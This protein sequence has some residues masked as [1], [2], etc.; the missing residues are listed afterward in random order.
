MKHMKKIALLAAAVLL[1]AV[2]M[3]GCTRL[4]EVKD[5]TPAGT[6]ADHAAAEPGEYGVYFKLTR[7]DVRSVYLH[8]GSFT[9]VC[10]N[11][12]GSL[13]KAGDWVFTGED[14]RELS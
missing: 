7:D 3:T 9:K 5:D 12:D 4:T 11:A 13:L 2:L 10:E 8:G 6:G 14:I 1:M